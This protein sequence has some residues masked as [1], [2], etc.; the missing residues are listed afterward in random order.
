MYAVINW[1]SS[2]A[3]IFVYSVVSVYT[4]V[5]VCIPHMSMSLFLRQH[6]RVCQ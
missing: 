1:D 6:L 2:C 5:S 3:V 4:P